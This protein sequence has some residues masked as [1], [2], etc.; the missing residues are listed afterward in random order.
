LPNLVMIFLQNNMF[1]DNIPASLGNASGI[2]KVDL[3]SNVFTGPVPSSFGKFSGLLSL[4]LDENDL[5]ASDSVSW[6]FLHAM[7]N[8]SSLQVLSLAQNKLTGHIPDS[9]V[10]L[11]KT[12]QNQVLGGNKLSGI[13]P[14]SLGKL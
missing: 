4:N 9:I 14:D 1:E 11:S 2:I 3:S 6:E 10:N 8:C 7:G 5:E 12:L 13:V